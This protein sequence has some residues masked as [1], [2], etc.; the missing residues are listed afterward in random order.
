[1]KL[2]FSFK[3]LLER[4]RRIVKILKNNIPNL[5][6]FQITA[7]DVKDYDKLESLNNE[8]WNNNENNYA[9]HY[10]HLSEENKARFEKVSMLNSE[11]MVEDFRLKIHQFETS[12]QS[13]EQFM[14]NMWRNEV[15]PGLSPEEIENFYKQM[16]SLFPTEFSKSN[17][18]FMNVNQIK[19]I[20]SYNVEIYCD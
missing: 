12:G 1:M 10:E 5:H 2:I 9:M 4:N 16:P 3:P 20:P 14:G 8:Y 15:A 17:P 6:A 13:I 7:L 19:K 18:D 11:E